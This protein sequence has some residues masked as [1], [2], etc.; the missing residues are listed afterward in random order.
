MKQPHPESRNQDMAPSRP[1]IRPLT[2]LD[3][4]N[5]LLRNILDHF[6][7]PVIKQAAVEWREA[8]RTPSELQRENRKTIQNLRLVCRALNDL[9]SPLLCPVLRV[10]IN[11]R[12]L[13]R[14][15]NLSHSPTVASGVRGI[16]VGLHCFPSELVNSLSRFTD[17]RLDKCREV[18]NA[19]NW[20]LE[21]IAMASEDSD[22]DDDDESPDM[23]G[24]VYRDA[25]KKGHSIWTSWR[26]YVKRAEDGGPGAGPVE[27]NDEYQEIL[28][29]G[30]EKF[31]DKHR[32][33]R[34]M[35]ESRSFV[36]TLAACLVRMPN[37]RAVGFY[38]ED[39][40]FG[41]YYDDPNLLLDTAL[42]ARLMTTPLS[43]QE[44]EEASDI[45]HGTARI[46]SDLPIAIHEAGVALRD[47][48]VSIFPCVRDQTLVCL[49]PDSANTWSKFRTACQSLRRASFGDA[50][51]NLPIRH[52]HLG[53]GESRHVNEYLAALVSGP[54][55][56][57]VRIYPRAFGLNDGRGGRG[58]YDL[59]PVLAT[60]G[61]P[62]VR[63]ISISC[64]G[65]TQT[66]VEAFFT[67]LRSDCVERVKSVYYYQC[68][69]GEFGRRPKRE[70]EWA[71]DYK[72]PETPSIVKEVEMYI[73]G[74]AMENPVRALRA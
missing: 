45:H 71:L 70:D 37:A 54:H 28:R 55:L 49:C 23:S 59:S 4:P 6:Q 12:S 62:R 5:E 43:W 24:A 72:R 29:T 38:H 35:L 48:D 56:E 18:E 19:C 50:L 67:G 14:A 47:L 57:T 11:Q 16:C 10:D 1:D 25:L 3:L 34:E 58:E 51:N 13:D 39:D 42:L 33:Q 73:S 31:R 30:H 60:V 46:L 64:V 2:I 68:Y 40:V 22:D 66:A 53:A 15:V 7:D 44:I 41:Q 21:G 27:A 63:D 36:R 8:R 20:H 26:N 65:V 69:G 17:I 32:E 61:W 52:S 9:S 74:A